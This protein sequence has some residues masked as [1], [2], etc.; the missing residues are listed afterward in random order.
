MA[1]RSTRSS[2]G[3]KNSKDPESEL[4]VNHINVTY[5]YTNRNVSLNMLF[6]MYTNA[7]YLSNK[8]NELKSV[9]GSC[10]THPHLIG[11]C[12]IMPKNFCST[13]SS[14]EFYVL[15][16]SLFNSNIKKM[17]NVHPFILAT[18]YMQH[19]LFSVMN[20]VDLFGSLYL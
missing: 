3:E 20:F 7:D 1:L 16:Y 14:S 19:R 18:F 6:C 11:V 4:T 13:T 2:I 5:Q 17:G 10:D 8:L 9:I 15:G 12:E